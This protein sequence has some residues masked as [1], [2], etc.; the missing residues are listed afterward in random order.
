M[1]SVWF[2]GDVSLLDFSDPGLSF[3][4]GDGIRHLGVSGFLTTFSGELKGGL[5]GSYGVFRQEVALDLPLTP[6]LC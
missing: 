6:G 5:G 2:T 1:R 4:L 3:L